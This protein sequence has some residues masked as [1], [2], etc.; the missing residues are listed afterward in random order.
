MHVQT[1]P[2]LPT[3]HPDEEVED[4]LRLVY[5]APPPRSLPPRLEE[6]VQLIGERSRSAASRLSRRA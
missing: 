2:P 5:R 3:H 4:N 1:Y 6:L